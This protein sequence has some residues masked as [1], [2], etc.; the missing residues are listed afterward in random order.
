MA[1]V[2]LASSRSQRSSSNG[3]KWTCSG[4][5]SMGTARQDHFKASIY[6]APC[7]MTMTLIWMEA[8][9]TAAKQTMERAIQVPSVHNRKERKI[10]DDG[11]LE[12]CETWLSS[13]LGGW[14][15]CKTCC[16]TKILDLLHTCRFISGTAANFGKC[17]S[18]TSPHIKCC[19]ASVSASCA[20]IRSSSDLSAT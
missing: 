18:S 13:K 14:H 10:Y 5:L 4:I 3:L 16:S 9:Q 11:D 2:G 19:R 8:S 1:V 6:Y 7:C 17:S 12:V 15:S 20:F